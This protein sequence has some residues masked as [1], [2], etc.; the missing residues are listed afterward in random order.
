MKSAMVNRR[1]LLI[2]SDL[3][4]RGNKVVALLDTVVN[5]LE[6]NRIADEPFMVLSDDD[7]TMRPITVEEL[8]AEI[9][10]CFLHQ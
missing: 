1:E 9:Q 4:N 8:K 7:I 2:S 5:H 6:G 10:R 3:I